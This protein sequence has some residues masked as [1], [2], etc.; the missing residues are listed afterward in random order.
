L[1]W[2]LILMIG[3]GFETTTNLI[4]NAVRALL[5]HPNQLD[6]VLHGR[7]RWG[8][9]VEETLR[10]DP[11]IANL[12]FRYATDTIDLDGVRIPAGE[13]VLIC[14]GAAGRDPDQH[15]PTA[16][17]FDITRTQRGHLAFSHGPHY[18]LGSPL[19]RLEARI[20]LGALFESFPHLALAVTDDDLHNQPSI[21]AGGVTE[22]PVILQPH[23]SGNPASGPLALPR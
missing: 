14:Y 11:P 4:T 8:A 20:A 13:P 7:C 17:R 23:D 1:I 6:Q 5:T 21:I 10:W 15:G 12:P 16:H 18:C 19:A 3:A 22:R 2:T 9:V